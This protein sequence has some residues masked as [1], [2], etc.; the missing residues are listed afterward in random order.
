MLSAPY[1]ISWR[2]EKKKT[3]K[4]GGDSRSQEGM[5]VFVGM[6]K[7]GVCGKEDGWS[8]SLVGHCAS[9]RVI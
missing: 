5:R 1:A 6:R 8:N 2:E 4:N 7:N 3:T 9:I